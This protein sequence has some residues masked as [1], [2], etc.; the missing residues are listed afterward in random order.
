MTAIAPG[1]PHLQAQTLAA[2]PRVDDGA[3]SAQAAFFRAALQGAA[4]APAPIAAEAPRS[5]RPEARSAP[6]PAPVPG[7]PGALL[8]IRV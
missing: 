3:R 2:Q 5:I 1:A 8:D 6:E 7:R 4:T